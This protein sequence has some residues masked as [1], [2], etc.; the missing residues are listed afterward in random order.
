[1]DWYLQALR[2]YATFTGRARRREFWFFQLFVLLIVMVLSLLDRM[3][4]LFD[5]ETSLGP[6]SGLF[7][8]AML[9]P[10][11]A[12]SVRRLHDTDRSGWWALLYF[13][14]LLGFLVLLVF[15]VLDGTRGANRFGEDPKGGTA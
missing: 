15:F 9:L 12:V 8:L 13:V 2:Q 6:L 7:S 14:P 3:L 4:G 1:M 10:S 11:L 5:D